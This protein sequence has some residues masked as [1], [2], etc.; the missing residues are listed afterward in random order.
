VLGALGGGGWRPGGF[1]GGGTLGLGGPHSSP[2]APTPFAS[3]LALARTARDVAA[4][5]PWLGAGDASSPTLPP[6][7]RGR[8]GARAHQAGEVSLF[9]AVVAHLA[10]DAGPRLAAHAAVAGDARAPPGRRAALL[11]H[12]LA[13]RICFDGA[14]GGGWAPGRAPGWDVP[15]EDAAAASPSRGGGGG[16]FADGGGCSLSQPQAGGRPVRGPNSGLGALVS[17]L[18]EAVAGAAAWGALEMEADEAEEG[19]GGGGAKPH[20]SAPSQA[21][22]TSA[23]ALDLASAAA[24]SRDVAAEPAA[25]LLRLLLALTGAAEGAGDFAPARVGGSG[26]T[27]ASQHAVPARSAPG[28]GNERAALDAAIATAALARDGPVRALADAVEAAGGSDPGAGLRGLL[29]E[30]EPADAARLAGGVL[31]SRLAGG[32]AIGVGVDGVGVGGPLAAAAAAWAAPGAVPDP[33]AFTPRPAAVL[34]AAAADL[35]ARPPGAVA[36]HA[37]GGYPDHL[38]ALVAGLAIAGAVLAADEEAGVRAAGGGGKKGDKAAASAAAAACAAVDD[39]A[40][41]AIAGLLGAKASRLALAPGSRAA[42]AA[43]R[44]VAA[45]RGLFS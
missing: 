10:A 15:P 39:A 38:A 33:A 32:A 25:G 11:R 27:T 3:L 2:V 5:R 19:D 9:S 18:V 30:L 20:A 35:D 8:G 24:V 7:L 14:L 28:G 44:T 16:G 43:A 37:A 23:S 36:L 12:S 41:A 40:D 6:G 17:A 22:A 45:E 26:T 31:A 42:L 4:G 13:W 1:G 29:A 34:A 21:A